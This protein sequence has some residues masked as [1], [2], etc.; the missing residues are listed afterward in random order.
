MS[1]MSEHD[2]GAP[3]NAGA[4]PDPRARYRTLPAPIRIADTTESRAPFPPS[5]DPTEGTD[6]NRDVAVRYPL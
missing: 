6:P 1:T 5:P 2:P 4:S 3:P